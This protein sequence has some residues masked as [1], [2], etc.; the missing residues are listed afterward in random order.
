MERG[1]SP[2]TSATRY[3]AFAK[4]CGETA[5][6]AAP[7][8]LSKRRRLGTG[9]RDDEWRLSQRRDDLLRGS[10]EGHGLRAGDFP[11][12]NVSP[13][14]IDERLQLVRRSRRAVVLGCVECGEGCVEL[15]VE[16]ALDV[17]RKVR[18]YS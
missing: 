4:T 17:R 10:Y 1:S 5:G 7:Q 8:G 9:Q 2:S 11:A 15:G 12:L 3:I 18:Y 6:P 16:L 13:H 14:G